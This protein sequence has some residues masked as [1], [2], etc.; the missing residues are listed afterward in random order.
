[1]LDV[2]KVT[3]DR[4]IECFE[5]YEAKD[6]KPTDAEW[7]QIYTVAAAWLLE[8]LCNPESEFRKDAAFAAERH[9]CCDYCS[10]TPEADPETC[11]N[12]RGLRQ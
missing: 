4:G 5:L 11:E 3:P 1:M 7:R 9:F 6:Y 2:S 12:C 10:I 8:E